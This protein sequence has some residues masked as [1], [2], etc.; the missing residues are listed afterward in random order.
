MAT[1]RWSKPL[2]A[3]STRELAGLEAFLAEDRSPLRRLERHRRFL[4]AGR[5]TGLGFHAFAGHPATTGRTCG[6]LALAG[7][8]PLRLILEVLVGEKLLLSRRP[9]EL[10]TAVHATQ[11]P[12][13]ELHRS[14]P[15]PGR[16][17]P[18]R[19]AVSS[20]CA[21]ARAPVSP[22]VCPQASDKRNAS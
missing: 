6:A 2:D 9:D 4:A 13:L 7:F 22:F 18:I 3:A 20:D 19:A 8:A 21:Y 1:K 12:V 17:I 11:D 14:L 15:R 16:S 5:A 10:G